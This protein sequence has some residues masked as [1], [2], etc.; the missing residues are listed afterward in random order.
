MCQFTPQFNNEAASIMNRDQNKES[1]FEQAIARRLVE[2]GPL[3]KR[4][5]CSRPGCQEP[6]NLW[7]GCRAPG[8]DSPAQRAPLCRV[9]ALGLVPEHR[10]PS[11]RLG[12]FEPLMPFM[13]ALNAVCCKLSFH[14]DRFHSVCGFR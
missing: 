4:L 11:V 8:R 10:I 7:R 3:P 2:C 14:L 13:L 12:T 6:P 5:H 9:A 1:A